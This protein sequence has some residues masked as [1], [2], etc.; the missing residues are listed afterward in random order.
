MDRQQLEGAALLQHRERPEHALRLGWAFPLASLGDRQRLDALLD[1]A[2]GE[3]RLEAGLDAHGGWSPQTHVVL[4]IPWALDRPGSLREATEALE[5]HRSRLQ[6]PP[7]SGL[8]TT[9]APAFYLFVRRYA[10]GLALVRG[11]RPPGDMPAPISGS[12]A[13]VIQALAP[14]HGDD[15]L[16]SQLSAAHPEDPWGHWRV[17]AD[18]LADHG[19][20]ERA[21]LVAHL[22]ARQH[23]EDASPVV[24]LLQPIATGGHEPIFGHRLVLSHLGVVRRIELDPEEDETIEVL[25]RWASIPSPRFL[26]VDDRSSGTGSGAWSA[27]AELQRELEASALE[28]PADPGE[29]AAHL[30]HGTLSGAES[31]GGWAQ[32]LQALPEQALADTLSTLSS[33]WGTALPELDALRRE[34][35]HRVMRAHSA[36]WMRRGL[37]RQE[38]PAPLARVLAWEATSG[39]RLPPALRRFLLE[40]SAG[41]RH[42]FETTLFH[43]RGKP[44]LYRTLDY[45]EEGEHGEQLERLVQ[46]LGQHLEA[47]GARAPGAPDPHALARELIV[48][49][50]YFEGNH[51]DHV[52]FVIPTGPLADHTIWVDSLWHSGPDDS[53]VVLGPHLIDWLCLSGYRML[54]DEREEPFFTE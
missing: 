17:Y 4:G 39:V 44:L 13:D 33:A 41:H 42:G 34:L 51:G 50:T 48:V 36:A 47:A 45:L 15:L 2:D 30:A 49:E 11:G 1:A 6:R 27:Q 37:W 46:L 21:R 35:A 54:F 18:W 31:W 38:G 28:P 24:P 29:V 53:R 7:L 23:R 25:C 12:N 16:G 40:I 19:Q 14:Y 3:L 5:H 22:C 43:L 32:A 10:P 8:D 9:E 52:G 26:L 20:P